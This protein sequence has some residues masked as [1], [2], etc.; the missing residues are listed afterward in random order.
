M[1]A[2]LLLVLAAASTGAVRANAPPPSAELHTALATNN[3][4]LA[5]RLHRGGE[6]IDSAATSTLLC[7]AAYKGWDK[8]VALLLGFKLGADV[9]HVDH[10]GGGRTAL[11]YTLAGFEEAVRLDHGAAVDGQRSFERT[12]AVL[13]GRA[14]NLALRDARSMS[15]LHAAVRARAPW[16]LRGLLERGAA[17][18]N[19]TTVAAADG[20]PSGQTP[21]LLLAW[22]LKRSLAIAATNVIKQRPDQL[23]AADVA[24]AA[25]FDALAAW[26][27]SGGRAGRSATTTAH[28]EQ[29]QQP[30]SA[31]AVAMALALLKSGASANA[32]DS[33]GFSALHYAAGYGDASLVRLLLRHGADAAARTPA[34]LLAADL[35][36]NG[37]FEQAAAALA[38]AG[39]A[40][41]RSLL[42]LTAD[43]T[44]EEF[45]RRCVRPRRPCLISGAGNGAAW[46]EYAKWSRS[47][48]V[49]KL[50]LRR[51]PFRA[52]AIPYAKQ[53][54]L[55]E[56]HVAL[57]DFIASAR[58][59][60]YVFSSNIEKRAAFLLQGYRSPPWI[61]GLRRH[62]MQFSLGPADSGAPWHFHLDAVNVL[63]L[64]RKRWRLLEPP[65]AVLSCVP[66]SVVAQ[67]QQVEGALAFVQEAGDLVY[68]PDSWAHT[69]EN[70][71][72][73]VGFAT[74]FR[75]PSSV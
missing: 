52:G 74:E 15:P 7:H 49:E 17:P 39:A 57:G 65:R 30:L 6:R 61:R 29:L 19:A 54:G 44:A 51:A 48:S 36:R 40:P 16:A 8:T 27:M 32:R 14:P 33:W 75:D 2:W 62:A 23:P 5:R 72:L 3:E 38:A 37:G 41:E 1:P 26:G 12:F 45:R 63:V 66:P 50:R 21:L 11:H 68:V 31:V 60:D 35:A 42:R 46:P 34:G 58:A 20:L 69:V 55:V 4:R 43:A 25:R 28:R 70:L 18:N 22:G 53:Y 10:S 47:V 73:S 13:L 71:A 59:P 67:E 24:A 56:Q 64:G 9:D